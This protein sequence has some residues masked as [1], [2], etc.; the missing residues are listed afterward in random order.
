MAVVS[1]KSPTSF[2]GFYPE[3][4]GSSLSLIFVP[5]YHMTRGH[6]PG[7]MNIKVT[8]LDVPMDTYMTR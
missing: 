6:V 3:N 5:F 2:S 1:E 8:N 7:D 4:G